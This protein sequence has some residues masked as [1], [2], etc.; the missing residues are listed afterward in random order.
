MIV[1]DD[2]LEDRERD[3]F[4]PTLYFPDLHQLIQRAQAN[5]NNGRNYLNLW[6]SNLARSIVPQTYH[7]PELENWCV[8]NYQ[9]DRKQIIY[10]HDSSIV[11]EITKE[12]IAQMLKILYH[13]VYETLDDDEL[14]S[15]YQ[16]LSQFEREML[17]SN[18]L[19]PDSPLPTSPPPFK[20]NIF[21][22]FDFSL[23]STR[24]NHPHKI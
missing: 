21:L 16:E 1:F 4:Y 5:T 14:E 19:S 9:V 20:S 24:V 7:F 8:F 22:G 3:V 13:D 23:M 11:Y 10:V 12:S 15:K 17:L 2:H 18:L 6:E